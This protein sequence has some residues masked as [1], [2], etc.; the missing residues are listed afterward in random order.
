MIIYNQNR[1]ISVS[2]NNLKYSIDTFNDGTYLYINECTFV[3]D[4]KEDLYF[5]LKRIF[6][7]INNGDKFLRLLKSINFIEEDLHQNNKE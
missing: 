7:G 4:K 2:E 6:E 5:D 1:G 3:Y